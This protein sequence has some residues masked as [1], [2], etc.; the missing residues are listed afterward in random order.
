MEARA[1]AKHVRVSPRKARQVVDLIRGKSAA[2]AEAIIALTP[3]AAAEDVGRVLKS[4]MANAEKNHD[5]R[6]DTLFVSEAFVD[7]GPTMKRI[8][9]RAMGRAFRIRKRTSHITI[10]VKQRE[11]A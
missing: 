5:M 11:E 4:A 9:P 2:Q 3:R 8:Q 10:I 1:T 7:E 6:A